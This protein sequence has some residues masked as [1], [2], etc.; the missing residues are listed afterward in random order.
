MTLALDFAKEIMGWTK[1]L[2]GDVTELWQPDPNGEGNLYFD[3][4]DLNQV[5]EAMVKFCEKNELW[6]SISR[7]HVVQ[8]GLYGTVYCKEL[9]IETLCQALM[10]ATLEAA[11]RKG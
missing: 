4:A 1:P 2:Q 7:N 11:R 8:V 9:T 6:W 3:Y 10:Q 5:M